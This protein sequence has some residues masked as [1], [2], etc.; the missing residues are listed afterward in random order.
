MHDTVQLIT[1]VAISSPE[2]LTKGD[3]AA[4]DGCVAVIPS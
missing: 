3:G 4:M 2:G 1:D